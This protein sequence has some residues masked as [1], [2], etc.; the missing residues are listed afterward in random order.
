MKCNPMSR[1]IKKQSSSLPGL[2]QSASEY[3]RNI[4]K[5]H[6]RRQLSKI[7]EQ[8]EYERPY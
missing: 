7:N 2:L 3:R 4:L 5:Y 6:V 1:M 8:F